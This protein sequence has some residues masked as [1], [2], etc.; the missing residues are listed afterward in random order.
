MRTHA[1]LTTEMKN[2]KNETIKKIYCSEPEE[3]HQKIYKALK[4]SKMPLKSRQMKI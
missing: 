4:I 1:I 2:I 3:F